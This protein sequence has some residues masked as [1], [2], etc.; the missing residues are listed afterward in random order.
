ML[1]QQEIRTIRLIAFWLSNRIE[2]KE[3]QIFREQTDILISD[4]S[5]QISN[6]ET[7]T[8]LLL[9]YIPD[10]N[11]LEVKYSKWSGMYRHMRGIERCCVE[12][13]KKRI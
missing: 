6:G 1:S 10:S 4:N 12:L 2:S 9:P 11:S 3:H 7:V 13:V 8:D 5:L